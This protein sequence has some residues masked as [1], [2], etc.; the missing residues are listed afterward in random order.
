MTALILASA[1]PRRQE[2]LR[3]L[4]VQFD[5]D[6]ANVDETIFP[7]EDP[8]AAVRRLSLAKANEIGRRYPNAFVLA[9]DTIV[10]LRSND[11]AVILGKPTTPADAMGMLEQLQGSTHQVLTGFSIINIQQSVVVV[12]VVETNVTFGMLSAAEIAA[13]V[14]TGEGL[15]KAGAYALQ[16]LGAWFVKDIHG[17][18]SN[19]IGLPLWEVLTQL[20]RLGVWSA[21]K[22]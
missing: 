3:S 15:D 20:K 22:L 5:I 2:L 1:S 13:Y 12:D 21:D 9:A 8:Q 19:V 6:P 7:G 10:V 18:Y 16:G 17:S 11:S 14:R 4:G